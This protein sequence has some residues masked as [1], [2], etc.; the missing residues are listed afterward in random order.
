MTIVPSLS[1]YSMIDID[2]KRSVTFLGD[3]KQTTDY[4]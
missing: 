4:S 1:K 3:I 2:Q